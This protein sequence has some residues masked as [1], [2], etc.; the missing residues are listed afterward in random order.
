MSYFNNLPEDLQQY[1]WKSYFSNHIL[2]ELIYWNNVHLASKDN[3]ERCPVNW[4]WCLN[5][6]HSKETPFQN[7]SGQSQVHKDYDAW[8]KGYFDDY[9][10][11]EDEEINEESD[12]LLIY[13]M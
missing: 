12:P 5:W 11:D 1:V 6:H 7:L 13:Y 4:R 3:T 9:T 10:T 8:E 2:A